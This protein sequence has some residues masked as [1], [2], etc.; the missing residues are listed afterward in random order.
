VI[1][2]VMRVTYLQIGPA[3]SCRHQLRNG[4]HREPHSGMTWPMT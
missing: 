2:R 3:Y 1:S 4:L